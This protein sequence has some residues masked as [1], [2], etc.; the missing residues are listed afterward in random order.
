MKNKVVTFDFDDTLLEWRASRNDKGNIVETTISTT[1]I[2]PQ[3]WPIFLKFLD[4]GCEVHIVTSRSS[5]SRSKVETI[6]KEWN[7]LHR[8]AG[9]HFSD[10]YFKR[11]ILE[12]LGSSIHHD[13]D[14]L[15]LSNLPEGCEGWLAPVHHSWNEV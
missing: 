12:K 7:V 11:N 4:E 6:L 3:T 15:E 10:G 2:N 14:E 13:D 5:R 8:I 9:I 1:G